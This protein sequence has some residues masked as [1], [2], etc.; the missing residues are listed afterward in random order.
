MDDLGRVLGAVSD[1]TRRTIIDRLAR[2][3]ARVTD[4]AAPFSMSLNAISK[5]VK[6]LEC[7]GLVRR[8]RQGR[9][10]ILQLNAAPLQQVSRWAHRYARFWSERMDR[11]DTF[12]AEKESKR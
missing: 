6:V 2:G 8:D 9:E 1:P 5:H 4:L 7:A 10:H 11:L 12:F 3:P